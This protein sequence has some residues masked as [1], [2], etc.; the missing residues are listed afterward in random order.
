MNLTALLEIVVSLAALYWL[1]AMAC[2]YGVEAVNSMLLNVRAKALERFVCEM[3]LGTGKVPMLRLFRAPWGRSL[4]DKTK[5]GGMAA[6]N[7][8]EGSLADPLGLF[9]HGLVKSLRKPRH[10]STGGATPPSYI[11]SRVFAQA[12]LDR[13]TQLSW[14]TDPALQAPAHALLLALAPVQPWAAALSTVDRASPTPVL[15]M[16][17]AL[18]KSLG[19]ETAPDACRALTDWQVALAAQAP[20]LAVDH[21][22]AIVAAATNALQAMPQARRL[23]LEKGAGW[24][25]KPITAMR[26]DEA[27]GADALWLLA[28]RIAGRDM[29]V[30]TAVPLAIQKLL[31]VAPLPTALK[32][33]LRPLLAEP[34]FNL[35]TLLQG[36]ERWYED[37]MD[38]ASG[39]FKR[40][41]TMVLG[42]LGLAAAVGL[43]VNTLNV[44]QDLASDPN[45]RLAGVAAAENIYLAGGRPV[46]A[47]QVALLDLAKQGQWQKTAQAAALAASAAASTRSEQQIGVARGTV[48]QWQSLRDSLR[49]RLLRSGQYVAAMFLAQRQTGP[50]FALQAADA[51]MALAD[52]TQ[53]RQALCTAALGD[54]ATA[55]PIAP[56]SAPAKAACELGSALLPDTARPRVA[57]LGDVWT[58]EAVVWH[59]ALS[60]AL[61]VLDEQA[62]AFEAATS[63][64]AQAQALQPLAQAWAE[65]LVQYGDAVQVAQAEAGQA[66]AFLGRIPSLQKKVVWARVGWRD[67]V[68][69]LITAF[70]VS[71]GAPFWFDLL[72]KLLGQR[73]ATGP[74][75][76]PAAP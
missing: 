65:V 55:S 24:Q 52:R 22:Q 51:P 76:A 30:Q 75:P 53:L 10:L 28:V 41:V 47:Q 16:A 54:S 57:E 12:L 60:K 1:L 72:S 34:Q 58:S 21:L 23:R 74:K 69:W 11:P 3:V 32:E 68:G 63:A 38:R 71:F 13:L 18:L 2:S 67:I 61:F 37:V 27:I 39:W 9:S 49:A 20:S 64:Q 66:E 70:M 7:S 29:V 46:L 6:S 48:V 8:G 31:V 19:R 14:C 44:V 36:V 26:L 33:A 15:D 56:A 73:G 43:N 62:A 17:A 45:L 50:R 5:E 40:N 25:F 42:M 59:P 35:D 4:L